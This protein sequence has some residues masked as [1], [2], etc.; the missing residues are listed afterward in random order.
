MDGRGMAGTRSAGIARRPTGPHGS[1]RNVPRAAAAMMA[2]VRAGGIAAAA[3][4]LV[5]GAGPA[6]AA[7]L[8]DTFFT[9]GNGV[10]PCY[11]RT[12]DAAHLAAHPRQRVTA[13]FL[14]AD[15]P[16][17]SPGAGPGK[18]GQ[19][20]FRP[21]ASGTKDA[22]NGGDPG[23]RD[24]GLDLAFGFTLKNNP[25]VYEGLATC[26]ASGDGATC[27]V[28]G[29][30]GGFRLERNRDGRLRIVIDER[31]EVEG[32]SGFSPDLATGG[33]DSPILLA[34]APPPRCGLE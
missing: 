21:G 18:D 5:V 33:D 9:P 23:N 13:F 25:D 27:A 34:L 32:G 6:S 10:V 14:R 17:A 22:G 31:F 29:D 15:G 7:P 11:A 3:T 12:Y 4:V 30:G 2:A 19:S 8:L 16:A 24:G 20:V 1:G 28:E 26:A